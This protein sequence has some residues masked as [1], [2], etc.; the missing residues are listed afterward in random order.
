MFLI[1]SGAYIEQDL[2]NEVGRLPPAFLP[3]GNKRLYEHQVNLIRSFGEDVVVLSLPESFRPSVIDSLKL[4]S[5]G[6][7][8]VYCPEGLSLGESV[9]FSWML[10]ECPDGRFNVLHGD[11]LFFE[12]ARSSDDELSVHNNV[13]AYTRAK[14]RGGNENGA[15]KYVSQWVD[16]TE[17][18]L[19]G[20]FSISKP[21][22]FMQSITKEGGD[23]VRALGRY[24]S[25]YPF[26]ENGSGKW[27]D[28]GHLNAFFQSRSALTTQRSFNSLR[29]DSISVEKC[30]V[31]SGKMIAECSWFESIPSALKVY[32]PQLLTRATEVENGEIAGYGLEYLY[33]MPLNDLFV[34][35]ALSKAEWNS[36]LLSARKV[37][38]DFCK[39]SSTSVGC[40]FD[41]LYLKKTLSRLE[42][43]RSEGGVK[44]QDVLSLPSDV[45]GMSA[46]AMA[47]EA[48]KRISDFDES[49][50]SV[51]HGDFCFSNLLYDSRKRIIKM[52]DPRGL[53]ASG[54]L[55][56]YGDP[57]YDLAKLY[58]SVIGMYDFII[59]GAYFEKGA[60]LSFPDDGKVSSIQA[61]FN[62]VF[63]S[64]GG[65]FNETEIIAINVQLFLSMIPLHADRPDRQRAMMLNAVRLY[66]MLNVGEGV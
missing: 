30:S 52:I 49:S 63:F 25:R 47:R 9:L 32:T 6:V 50:L 51:V 14:A 7:S 41:D 38:N 11:T 57:R 37:L 39:Y 64:E 2:A 54:V 45:L 61:I 18:V 17:L 60:E 29:I 3:V 10:A 44:S 66:K 40:S 20:F 13:G 4:E 55:S 16:G 53:D 24:N 58:H 27:L 31:D 34:F 42:Q 26:S 28:F 21:K 15:H 33:L 1:S 62:E 8:V 22:Y 65:R 35:G 23:F 36:V 59:A 43:Y 19:S 5:L 56:I 12:Y 46:E 48:A